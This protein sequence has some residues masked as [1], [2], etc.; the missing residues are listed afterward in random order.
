MKKRVVGLCLA[1]G[2]E[3]CAIFLPDRRFALWASDV[4]VA[5]VLPSLSA[6]SW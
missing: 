5:L 4:A 1:V 2:V 3:L 6:G